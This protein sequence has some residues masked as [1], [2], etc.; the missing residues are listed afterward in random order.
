[1]SPDIDLKSEQLPLCMNLVETSEHMFFN[2]LITGDE[3]W[4]ED[5][6]LVDEI[7]KEEQ[8][9]LQKQEQSQLHCTNKHLFS[10]IK[11][12]IEVGDK[13]WRD[14][15]RKEA[16]IKYNNSKKLLEI[17][18]KRNFSQEQPKEKSFIEKVKGGLN[19]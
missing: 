17:F 4:L 19:L 16:L 8:N 9:E 14:N 1:M 7:R 12:L 15:K 3:T 10:D 6:A 5:R 2:W 11:R 18:Y 13:L